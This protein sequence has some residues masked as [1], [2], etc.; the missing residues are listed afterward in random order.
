MKN[1]KVF[2]YYINKKV[3]KINL[4]FETE[5]LL[6][7]GLLILLVGS[8][9]Y[10]KGKNIY[11]NASSYHKKYG[12]FYNKEKNALNFFICLDVVTGI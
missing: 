5:T 10:S 4:F 11:R 12:E 9:K 1:D 6:T 7:F 2:K 3:R 8:A